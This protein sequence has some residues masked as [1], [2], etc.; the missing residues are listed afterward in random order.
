MPRHWHL[1]HFH[2]PL[3]NILCL[4]KYKQQNEEEKWEKKPRSVWHPIPN[5]LHFFLILWSRL[6]LLLYNNV[7]YLLFGTHF[8]YYLCLV[9]LRFGKMPPTQKCL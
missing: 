2:F 8:F 3:A 4:K 5:A 7:F 9:A 6:T 1:V